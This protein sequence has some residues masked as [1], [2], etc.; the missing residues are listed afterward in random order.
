MGAGPKREGRRRQ[1]HTDFWQDLPI[2]GS[3]VMNGLREPS[4]DSPIRKV[5]RDA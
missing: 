3:N 4:A 2:A 5:E 1:I